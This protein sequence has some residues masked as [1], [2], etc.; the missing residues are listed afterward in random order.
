LFD[1]LLDLLEL[2]GL[3]SLR[4]KK[5]REKESTSLEINDSAYKQD[6]SGEVTQQG[7]SICAGCHRTLEK[8]AIYESG[9]TWCMECYK[10]HILKI[11]S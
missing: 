4:K 2:L 5:K 8:G 10:T 6:T 7:V 1:I 3:I 9:K 11:K